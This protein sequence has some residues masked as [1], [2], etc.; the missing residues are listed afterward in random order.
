MQHVKIPSKALL[1]KTNG[2]GETYLH[3]ACRR[4]NPAQVMAL[5]QAGINVNIQDYAG[6]SWWKFTAYHLL[7]IQE[8]LEWRRFKPSGW[9]ALHEASANGD[10]EVVGQLLKAGADVHAR[11]KEGITPLHDAAYAGH[12]QVRIQILN[13]T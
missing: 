2:Y 12:Y 5:L 4:D 3:N 1:N 13:W 8:Q 6:G 9:T 11:S 7:A 10:A